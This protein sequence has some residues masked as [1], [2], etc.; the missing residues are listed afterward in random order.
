MGS[1]EDNE[2]LIARLLPGEPGARQLKELRRDIL[3]H[4]LDDLTT[5]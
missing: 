3:S 4:F 2:C 1:G 5:V